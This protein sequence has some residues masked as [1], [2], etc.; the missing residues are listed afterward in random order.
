[1]T[2]RR[3]REGCE[4]RNEDRTTFVPIIV[5]DSLDSLQAV[6]HQLVDVKE[7]PSKTIQKEREGFIERPVC[8]FDAIGALEIQPK[9]PDMP[10]ASMGAVVFLLDEVRGSERRWVGPTFFF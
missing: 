9:I 4:E 2:G 6:N 5:D 10:F 8:Q 3:V 7:Q 1:M